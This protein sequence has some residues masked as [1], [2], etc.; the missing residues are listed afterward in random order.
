MRLYD[1]DAGR[2]LT[3][4]GHLENISGNLFLGVTNAFSGVVGEGKDPLDGLI[5]PY[6]EIAKNLS[7]AVVGIPELCGWLGKKGVKKLAEMNKGGTQRVGEI[8][9]TMVNAI[10]SC[11][12]LDDG[13]IVYG[14][15]ACG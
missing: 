6:P 3:Y 9:V 10:H 1:F 5:R 12:I 8:E 14:G 7:P 13:K 11:G 4:R 15:E 2:W